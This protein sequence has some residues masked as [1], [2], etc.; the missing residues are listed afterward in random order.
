MKSSVIPI[1]ILGTILAI[2]HLLFLGGAQHPPGFWTFTGALLVCYSLPFIAL[3][4]IRIPEAPSPERLITQTL[5]VVVLT[6]SL[7]LPARR[8]MPGY[9]PAA[10]EGL[11]Y[12][13]I[14]AFEVA[15]IALFL[16]VRGVIARLGHKK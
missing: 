4:R 14:P 12:L 3:S 5:F 6:I 11:A 10:L 2:S 13:F 16:L 9:H 1:W 15:L 8:F 7:F